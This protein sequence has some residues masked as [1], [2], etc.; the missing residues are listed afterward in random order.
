MI[1]VGSCKGRMKE[2][3]AGLKKTKKDI[4][5]I[6]LDKKRGF[7]EI[8]INFKNGRGK[9]RIT[10]ISSDEIVL[11]RSFTEKEGLSKLCQNI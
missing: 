4:L 8:V 9:W 1:N 2:V 10:C 6:S 7:E 5:E 11:F 3:F